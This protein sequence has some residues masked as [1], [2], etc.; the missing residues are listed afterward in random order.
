VVGLLR[1]DMAARSAFYNQLVN[2]GALSPNEVRDLEDM[3]PRD[4]G[5]IYLTPLN[6]A[7]NGK[8]P[9]E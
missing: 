4:G 3:N 7:V 1:G 2:L 6:M 9:A 5:D 8:S